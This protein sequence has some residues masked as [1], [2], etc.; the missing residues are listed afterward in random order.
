MVDVRGGM[1][2]WTD[3]SYTVTAWVRLTDANRDGRP[4]GPGDQ[5]I[6]SQDGREQATFYLQYETDSGRWAYEVPTSDSGA[7]NW[8][9]VES[10]S[11]AAVNRWTH[12]AAVGNAGWGHFQLYVDG[13]L[14]GT[15]A[16]TTSPPSTGGFHL[17]VSM[18]G[19]WLVGALDD[20]RVRQRALQPAEIA[21]LSS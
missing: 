21:E 13:V 19:G 20:V 3:R 16:A 12:V 5:V 17:G 2:L 7:T 18:S 15:G 9:T 11:P 14:Q 4:D 10:M 8:P 1:T 6:A